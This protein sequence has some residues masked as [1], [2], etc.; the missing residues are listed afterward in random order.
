[1]WN[2][3]QTHRQ[4]NAVWHATCQEPRFLFGR[5]TPPMPHPITEF[6]P[7]FRLLGSPPRRIVTTPYPT[8]TY[9]PKRTQN[10]PSRSAQNHALSHENGLRAQNRAKFLFRT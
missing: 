8:G 5:K 10:L 2:T 3:R 7:L 6:S 4:Y 1:M 9:M